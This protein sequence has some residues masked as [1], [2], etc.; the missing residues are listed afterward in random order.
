MHFLD[1]DF[2]YTIFWGL[3]VVIVVVVA[4]LTT[5]ATPYFV[6]VVGHTF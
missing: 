5:N 2:Y 4:A 6:H 3:I 1:G